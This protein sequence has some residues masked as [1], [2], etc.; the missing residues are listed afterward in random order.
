MVAALLDAASMREIMASQRTAF[1]KFDFGPKC[2]DCIELNPVWHALAR[3]TP[4][5]L[6]RVDCL[7]SPDVCK[8]RMVSAAVDDL[9]AAEP[10]FKSFNGTRWRRLARKATPQTLK[11]YVKAKGSAARVFMSL[12]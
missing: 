9:E 5:T 1:V 3:E 8:E 12:R 2:K 10:V 7:D 4:G 6:W 11:E